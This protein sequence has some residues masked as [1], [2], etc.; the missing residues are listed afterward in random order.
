[1]KRNVMTFVVLIALVLGYLTFLQPSFAAESVK[2]IITLKTS[3]FFASNSW[4]GKQYQWWAN[5]LMKRTN[6]RVKVD[7]FWMDSLV[8]QADMLPGLKTKMTDAGFSSSSYFP[9]NLP[10]FTMIDLL[11]NAGDDYG[12]IILASLDTQENEPN[13]KAELE[14]EGVVM[15]AEHLTGF[16]AIAM[17]KRYGSFSELKGKTIRTVGA[18]HQSYFR[19]LGANPIFMPYSDIYEAMSRG[20][21]DGFIC[22]LPLSDS[23]KHYEVIKSA[24]T[25]NWQ[26]V[27]TSGILM[28]RDLFLRLP[29]DIQTIM[30]DLRKEFAGYYS[31]AVKND[32]SGILYKWIYDRGIN[33]IALTPEEKTFNAKLIEG[34][35]D[36]FIKEQEGKGYKAARTVWDYYLKSL[37]RITEERAKAKK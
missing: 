10:L 9:S 1:M 12:A 33:F 15:L 2:P 7:F 25:F 35:N 17:S 20:T 26:Q 22:A 29:K 28:N 4:A 23:M 34:A 31:D 24:I 37:K 11:G 21:V 19:A 18:V 36:A 13:L 3:V 27:T 32:I 16:G 8:K 6:G 5:E 30:M 14:R